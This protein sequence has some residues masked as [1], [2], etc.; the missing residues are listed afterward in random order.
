MTTLLKKRLP[1]F[2]LSLLSISFCI[3]ATPQSPAV[4]GGNSL[5][6]LEANWC[7]TCRELTPA[8]QGLAQQYAGKGLNIQVIDV[9]Q[10]ADQQKAQAMGIK[11][12]G[13]KLPR[14]FLVKSGQATLLFDGAQY[15]WGDAGKA[16]QSI[17]TQLNQSL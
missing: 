12:S 6:V 5:V 15:N 3:L 17:Q 2:L 9:D 11:V 16:L 10:P 7:A 1:I 8:V 14:V 13:G 4:E